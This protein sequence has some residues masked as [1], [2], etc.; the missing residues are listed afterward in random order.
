M[1][2]LE[3]LRSM[4]GYHFKQLPMSKHKVCELAQVFPELYSSK[5]E[6]T[7]QLSYWTEEDL[8]NRCRGTGKNSIFMLFYFFKMHFDVSTG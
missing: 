1:S 2:F 7:W 5:Q 3:R 6:L 4:F 8:R